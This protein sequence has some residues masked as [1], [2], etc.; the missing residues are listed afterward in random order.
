LVYQGG[1]RFFK[2]V[3]SPKIHLE[4]AVCVFHG[5]PKPDEVM[6]QFVID[7]WR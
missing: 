2:D 7:N 1:K 6:D 5:D 3:R 4:C